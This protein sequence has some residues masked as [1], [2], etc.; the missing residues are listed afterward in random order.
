MTAVHAPGV[1]ARATR[2]ERFILDL[3]TGVERA[4]TAHVERR[5]RRAATVAACDAMR[6]ARADAHA[7]GNIG[8]LPR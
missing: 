8:M 6:D 4:V 5:A 1:T 7:L 2:L 3:A